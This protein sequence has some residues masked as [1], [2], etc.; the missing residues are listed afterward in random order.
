MEIKTKTAIILISTLL[1]GMVIGFV[2][3]NVF[4]NKRMQRFQDKGFK[5]RFVEILGR[6][7][8]PD[9]TQREEIGFVMREF[10]GRFDSINMNHHQEVATLM[11]SLFRELAPILDDDQQLRLRKVMERF[12]PEKF[13]RKQKS[14]RKRP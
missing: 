4:S 7:I 5:H 11:D 1:L 12:P 3:G 2:G 8:R 13:S 10:S 6:T 9:K 14:G